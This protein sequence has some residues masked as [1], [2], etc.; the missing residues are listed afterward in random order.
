MAVPARGR[1]KLPAGVSR[2]REPPAH[3]PETTD[4]LPSPQPEPQEP[5]QL[6]LQY[7]LA[8]R[9]WEKRRTRRTHPPSSHGDPYT[10][11][12]N[13]DLDALTLEPFFLAEDHC[14][15]F[16]AYEIRH[17]L[18]AGGYGFVLW[19]TLRSASSDPMSIFKGR[20]HHAIKFQRLVREDVAEPRAAPY[21][22]LRIL[23]AIKE[24]TSHWPQEPYVPRNVIG[25]RDYVRCKM[26]AR[27]LYQQ[28]P[29][30][31]KPRA[32]KYMDDGDFLY[33]IL[34]LE[35]AP[36]GSLE[37]FMKQGPQFLD[38]VFEPK[39]FQSL[40]VQVFATLRALGRKLQLTMHDCKIGNLLLRQLPASG[41]VKYLRYSLFDSQT[42]A[43]GT[44][45]LYVP[46]ENSKRLFF[47]LSDFG[48]ARAQ[49][50]DN[51]GSSV[52]VTSAS[53]SLPYPEVYNERSDTEL[54]AVTLLRVLI[55]KRGVDAAMRVPAG[56][57]EILTMCIHPADAEEYE[58]GQQWFG[59]QLGLVWDLDN[60]LA[61]AENQPIKDEN[62]LYIRDYTLVRLF[63]AAMAGK[64]SLGQIPEVAATR[65]QH[66]TSKDADLMQRIVMRL[67]V[68]LDNLY[69]KHRGRWIMQRRLQ[70]VYCITEILLEPFFQ[71]LRLSLDQVAQLQGV[72]HMNDFISLPPVL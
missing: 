41:P 65:A 23:A 71:S 2:K 11:K 55:T 53:K 16:S 7:D 67:V 28:L 58:L 69:L 43:A 61:P 17:F 50:P 6:V 63:L 35:Y 14:P 39:M 56:V 37:S 49:L 25:L 29:P 68:A 59:P 15:L 45:D 1:V 66:G 32:D 64:Y 13:E 38:S 3:F 51:N 70:D 30:E 48:L 31:D 44:G 47:Q 34:I 12:L 5:D 57:T 10:M 9:L 40:F 36:L 22:E 20:M 24:L 52:L 54:F 4:L 26:N 42:T 62:Y 19:A 33:Q 27:K 8:R 72:Y 46:V 21:V 60:A 18:G